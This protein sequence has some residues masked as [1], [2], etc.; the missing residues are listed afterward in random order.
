M[1]YITNGASSHGPSSAPLSWP[2]LNFCM[3]L[4]G[5]Y[6]SGHPN[7]KNFAFMDKLNLRSIMYLSSDD[8]R[9]HTKNWADSRNLNVFHHRVECS[10]EPFVEPDEDIVV[11]ALE[12]II[13]TRNLPILIHDNKGRLMPSILIGL[14]RLM[15]HWSFT[16]MLQ[17]YRT[18]L[19]DEKVW[20]EGEVGKPDK[21]RERIADIEFI[22]RFPLERVTYDPRYR[23]AW[24]E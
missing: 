3:V 15:C 5:V 10:K 17:E 7:D 13:D 22:D 8:Y 16:A 12:Q 24:L 4:P 1:S 19:P 11:L 23:P 18:F 21:G 6:R 14:I 2:P 9:Q 20:A